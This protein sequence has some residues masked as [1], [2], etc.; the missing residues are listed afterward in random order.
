[1]SRKLENSFDFSRKRKIRVRVNPHSWPGPRVKNSRGQCWEAHS[2]CRQRQVEN[3]EVS[4]L[5]MSEPSEGHT[6]VILAWA[7]QCLPAHGKIH[8]EALSQQRKENK[9]QNIK[10]KN[11]G[12][13]QCIIY[14]FISLLHKLIN[15]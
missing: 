15:V 11:S 2:S 5:K 6:A 4:Y 10:N 1:M 12:S 7:A 9:L 3:R 8:S 14:I 13:P